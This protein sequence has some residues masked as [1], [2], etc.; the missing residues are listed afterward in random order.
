M[1]KEYNIKIFGHQTM[2]DHVNEYM[3]DHIFQ[4]QRKI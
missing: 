1:A 2:S 3:K 4:L